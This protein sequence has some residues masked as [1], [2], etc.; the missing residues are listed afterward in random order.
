MTEES[1]APQTGLF[2]VA[3]IETVNCCTRRCWFCKFGQPRESAPRQHMSWNLIENIV[4]NLRDL[5]YR[6]RVSWFIINEPL[7]G[8]ANVRHHNPHE[9]VHPGLL[10]LSADKWRLARRYDVRPFAICGLDRLGVSVYDDGTMA[11]IRKFKCFPK[12]SVTYDRRPRQEI[13][14]V[15]TPCGKYLVTSR[16]SSSP[17]FRRQHNK[18]SAPFHR[19]KH[20]P[21]WFGHS[22][23]QRFL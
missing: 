7:P 3:L 12:L 21:G 23:L 4:F 11:K 14:F 10:L 2:T 22:L 19:D 15:E 8:Q 16:K 1:T 17:Q 13:G 5:D 20:C 18:L 9:T 6:G